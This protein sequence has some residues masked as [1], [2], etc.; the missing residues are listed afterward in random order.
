MEIPIPLA[1]SL[2]EMAANIAKEAK[3]TDSKIPMMIKEKPVSIEEYNKI[4]IPQPNK[5]AKA[6]AV[7][8]PK[9]ILNQTR[10]LAT[11]W[12]RSSSINCEEL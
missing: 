3:T 8:S 9:N 7:E 12:L 6:K 2:A 5:N 1:R 11:G 10:P 4:G